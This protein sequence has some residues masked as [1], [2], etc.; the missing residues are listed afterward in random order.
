[1]LFGKDRGEKSLEDQ[2]VVRDQLV[3]KDYEST[4]INWTEEER[5]R[6]EKKFL[7]KLDLRMSILVIVRD[8][9]SDRSARSFSDNS[10][11]LCRYI[12]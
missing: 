6:L 10:D 12:S 1:M 7:L 5:T 2:P 3:G 4:P 9:C 11:R 8:F